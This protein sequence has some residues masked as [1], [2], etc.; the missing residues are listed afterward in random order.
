MMTPHFAHLQH[1]TRRQFLRNGSLGLGAMALSSLMGGGAAAADT[2]TIATPGPHHLPKAKRVIY[3]H[4]SGS[5]P[6]LDLFDYKP[7][8]VKRSGQ[9]CPDDFIK[10]RRFAFTSGVPKLLGSPREFRQYGEA[11]IWMSDAIPYFHGIADDICMVNSMYTDQFNHAP[12]ELLMLTGHPRQGRPSLGSW[13]TYGLGSENSDLPAFI[14]M[15]SSGSQ[16]SAGQN[17]WGSGFL[18]SVHQGV[19]CQ[20]KGDPVV[21]VT[22]PPGMDRDLRRKTLDALD[23]IN[24]A[25]YQEFG[26]PETLTRISQFELSYRMQATAPE[27]MDISREPAHVLEAYGAVP[28][29]SSLANNCLLARRLAEQDVRYIQLFDWGWDFHGTNPNEDIRDGLTRK[30]ATM[31]KPVAALIRDLKERGL[32]DD[33]LVI[34]TGEFG[35]T[36]FREGRT[37]GGDILGRDHYPDCYTMFMAG[38]GIKRGHRHGATDELGFGVTADGVH[39]HDL[40]ATIMHLLGFDHEKLTFRHQGRDFR[41]TD[42]HGKVVKALLA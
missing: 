7:E 6:N 11:G 36:P 14:V 3:I 27:V 16:P 32:L 8:L 42:V 35:R 17:A 38:G 21:Y 29:A 25:Q 26:N 19:Q 4:L 41:L 5:P 20:S 40:Q 1:V 23:T 18:P 37:A 10:G 9:D 30:C 28:G 13:V 15:I 31:D 22:N 12:A 39:V 33:T 24:Q 2:P 34:W